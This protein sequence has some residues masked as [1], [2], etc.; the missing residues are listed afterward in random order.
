MAQGYQRRASQATSTGTARANKLTQAAGATEASGGLMKVAGVAGLT[1][2]ALAN[3]YRATVSATD[4]Q[5]QMIQGLAQ[6]SPSLAVVMVEREI[7]EMLRDMKH[8]ELI[9]RSSRELA[10]AEQERKDTTLKYE[11]AGETIVNKGLTVL[12]KSITGL[13]WAVEDL[14]DWVERQVDS[15]AKARQDKENAD[16][17]KPAEDYSPSNVLAQEAEQV[18]RARARN[19]AWFNRVRPNTFLN[20]P[21]KPQ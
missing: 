9:A 6:N 11:V 2:G 15:E 4:A 7:R 10:R 3:F 18:D 16:R 17:F 5:I 21:S 20:R 12:N 14:A 19:D 13:T 1:V 8:G